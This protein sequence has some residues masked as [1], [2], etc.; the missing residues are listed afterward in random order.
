MNAITIAS[1]SL[2]HA[3]SHAGTSCGITAAW[4]TGIRA[5][6]QWSASIATG[7][8]FD[9]VFPLRGADGRFRPF[10]TRVMPLKDAEGRVV[11][12]FGTNTDITELD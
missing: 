6:E 12:W 10:Q 5:A 4:A 8:P 3:G 2:L 7:Q 9:M 1:G 11:E